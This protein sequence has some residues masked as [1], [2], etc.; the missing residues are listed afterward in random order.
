MEVLKDHIRVLVGAEGLLWRNLLVQLMLEPLLGLAL[1]WGFQRAW[2][3]RQLPA[4]VI[5]V[6]SVVLVAVSGLADLR[7][8]GVALL[9]LGLYAFATA[10][11][12]GGM[13][14]PTLATIFFG[15]YL[16]YWGAAKY[17][18]PAAIAIQPHLAGDFDRLKP[19]VIVGVSF[20]G[21]KLIHFFVDRRSGDLQDAKPLEVLAWLLFFPAIVAGPMQR[22]Q[23]WR[24]QRAQKHA[25]DLEDIGEGLR[26]LAMGMVLKFVL[27]DSVYG[28]TLPAMTPGELAAISPGRFVLAAY[29]Y[30]LYL[31][32][33]FSGYSHMAIGVARFWGIRLPEN[34]NWPFVS[35]NLSEFWNRWHI[36]LSHIL[37]DYLFYP[38]SL[39][40]K[41][42][43][44]FRRHVIAG[45]VA[46]PVITFLIAGIWHGA[47]L[48]FIIF[49]LLHGV[50]LAVVALLQR[51]SGSSPFVSWWKTSRIGYVL[52]T[53]M[54]FSYVTLTLIFMLPVD[55]VLLAISGR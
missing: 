26:R 14:A 13:L 46:P 32:W 11:R 51:Y 20:I 10:R 45:L 17:L 40:V 55:N 19:F 38:L 28:A 24:D 47:G 37:R 6:A 53:A 21:F 4:A 41:R 12:A 48:N 49:G 15:A 7:A 1:A 18:A 22:F 8:I 36:T 23:D 44:F 27:A 42:R 50:G 16:A 34:F 43:K 5:L 2:R 39:A 54:T 31:Y 25:P 9:L 35:R 30:T 52:A 33:D 3:S 29:L